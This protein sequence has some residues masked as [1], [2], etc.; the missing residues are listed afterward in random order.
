MMK[1]YDS[2]SLVYSAAGRGGRVKRIYQIAFWIF[3]AA[4]LLMSLALLTTSAL[5]GALLLSC[6]VLINPIFIEKVKLKK[7][8]TAILAIG[9]FIASVS[10]FPTE[11]D[12]AVQQPD[13]LTKM[14]P[15]SWQD[16]SEQE[17]RF[18]GYRQIFSHWIRRRNQRQSPR[19][20][21]R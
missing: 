2:V 16:T 3:S 9:L 8:L 14:S 13:E 11:P 17:T 10:V 7:G 20:R 21:N 5:S 12:V 4:L 15:E 18:A 1:L 6:A 19:Q